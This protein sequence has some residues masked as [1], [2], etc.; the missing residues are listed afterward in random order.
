MHGLETLDDC[1][2]GI[3]L[4]SWKASVIARTGNSE[5]TAFL[6]ASVDGVPGD[7]PQESSDLVQIVGAP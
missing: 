4:K 5:D 6:H 7:T 3:E 2:V 1:T